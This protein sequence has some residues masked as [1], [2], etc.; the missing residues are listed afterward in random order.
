MSPEEPAGS[1]EMAFGLWGGMGPANHVLDGGSDPSRGRGNF[2]GIFSPLNIIAHGAYFAA[3]HQLALWCSD[4][5][6][7]V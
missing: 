3:V 4:Q 7:Q 2:G 1:I 6:L 5:R